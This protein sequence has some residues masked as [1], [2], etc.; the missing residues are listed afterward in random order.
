M[1]D[2]SSR[3]TDIWLYDLARG[4]Q[5]RFTAGP[6]NNQTPLWSPDGHQ[7]VFRS[8][9]KHQDDLYQKAASGAGAEEP[10]LE[11]EGQ[12]IPDD[13]SSDGRFLA[14][15]FR[16][17]KGDR[18]VTLSILSV[19]G[20]RKLTPFFRRGVNSGDARFSPDGRWLA[21]TSEESGRNE[22]YAAPSPAPAASGRSRRPA[23]LRPGGGGTARSSFIS[24]RISS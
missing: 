6:T 20:E 18:R 3:K 9:R 19:S 2:P 5:T 13:W 8:D 16:E 7:I 23:V 17:P 14:L 15:E 24:P 12:R 22:I 21:Y 1:L 10:L 4:I 11:G